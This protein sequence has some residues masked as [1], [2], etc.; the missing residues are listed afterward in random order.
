MSYFS[1]AKSRGRSITSR[2][3]LQL[4]LPHD[5][6]ARAVSHQVHKLEFMAPTI[7]PEPE[8]FED[9]HRVSMD[10]VSRTFPNPRSDLA[11]KKHD[12]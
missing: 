11:R 1:T 2:P 5:Q 7:T 12:E 9:L 3:R 10:L 6:L 8:Y 4:L